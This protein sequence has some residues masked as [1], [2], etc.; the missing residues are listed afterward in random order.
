M[1]V[2]AEDED[3]IG[4]FALHRAQTALADV[5]EPRVVRATLVVVVVR[6]DRR[7]QARRRPEQVEAVEP[8]RVLAHLVDLVDRDRMDAEREGR[9]AGHRDD[10]TR[11]QQVGE[12]G[13][14]GAADPLAQREAGAARPGKHVRR[15]PNPRHGRRGV[16][17][18]RVPIP[19]RRNAE[20]PPE[21]LPEEL[22][23]PLRDLVGVLLEAVGGVE[24]RRGPV[25]HP[26]KQAAVHAGHG[27]GRLA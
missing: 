3:V 8:S 6:D 26:R 11:C 5:A 21:V 23:H 17:G 9:G 15:G 18:I 16:N 19:E 13:R 10:A 27:S 1:A 22:D 4:Q 20:R 12:R 14:D 25:G 2:H 24:Q 7:P